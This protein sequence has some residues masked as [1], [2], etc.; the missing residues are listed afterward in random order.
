MRIAKEFILR[1]IAG[2]C[3]L[4]PTGATTQEFNGLITMSDT[5]RFIWEN[6]DKAESLKEM[7]Q[8]ILDEYEIDEETAKKDAI[9]FISQLLQAGFV[10]CTKED[11]TW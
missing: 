3:V 7:I 4:V 6:M 2:E 5:A 10:E 8:M 11:K 9:G 1:E